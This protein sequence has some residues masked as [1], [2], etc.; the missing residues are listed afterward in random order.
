M[1]LKSDR[2]QKNLVLEAYGVKLKRLTHDKI[3]MVRMWRNNPKIQ[4]YME[5]REEITPE[6]QEK[7]YNKISSSGRDF[8]FIINYESNEIGLINIRDVDFD[9]GEGEPGIF[10]WDDEYLNSGL[11]FRASLCLLDWVFETLKLNKT[12]AHILSDNI[13]SKQFALA[14]GYKLDENQSNVYNQRYTLLKTDY[15]TC[16]DKILKILKF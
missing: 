6:M 11:S 12:T 1:K 13:R 7:W 3:E 15:Y 8:Y 9:L 14:R 16:R 4:Q 10:I 2:Y 5:Y